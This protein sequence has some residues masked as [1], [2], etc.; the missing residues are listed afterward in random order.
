V[1]LDGQ[2]P[3]DKREWILEQFHL[4]HIKVLVNCELLTEGFDA[5]R[6][7]CVILAR[8]TLS[9]SLF[10]QMIGRGTRL[11]EGKKECVILDITDNCTKHRLRP[12][13]FK[14]IM[15]IHSRKQNV[16]L[17]EY[18]EDE[19]QRIAE[20]Q[21]MAE[22]RR[23]EQEQARL[24]IERLQL[25]AIRRMAEIAEG[26]RRDEEERRRRAIQER[27]DIQFTEIPLLGSSAHWLQTGERI[28]VKVAYAT[29]TIQPSSVSDYRYDVWIETKYGVRRAA[30]GVSLSKA[31]EMAEEHAQLVA[32]KIAATSNHYATEKQLETLRNM[33]IPIP[34][35]CTRGQASN[36][37]AGYINTRKSQGA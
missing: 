34:A 20:E 28:T 24:E 33:G 1:A 25:E 11:H 2:T 4:G 37:I 21:R 23:L 14:D 30:Q 5:P 9:R 31:K 27:R 6:V 26:K 18:D 36:L 7:G 22:E 15:G 17:L 8:P 10:L 12:Q 35:N 16:S 32:T 3:T 19:K 13:S 29:I